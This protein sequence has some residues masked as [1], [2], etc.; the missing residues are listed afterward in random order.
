LRST[1]STLNFAYG[2]S[3][4]DLEFINFPQLQITNF[5]R[6]GD[7]LKRLI[8]EPN[9]LKPSTTKIYGELIDESLV[10]IANGL[11]IRTSGTATLT[12]S[13]NSKAR[14]NT[15]TGTVEDGFFTQDDE[16]AVTLY[17]FITQT[18]GW[19]VV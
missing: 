12:L 9:I 18:K 7:A 1:G 4:E 19:T 8:V 14:L 2:S 17:D 15:L 10:S 6:S 16:G 5:N 3:V 11:I 13:D